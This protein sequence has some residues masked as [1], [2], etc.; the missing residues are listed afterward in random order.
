MKKTAS[1]QPPTQPSSHPPAGTKGGART[2]SH[3]RAAGRGAAHSR[4]RR[5]PLNIE[6]LKDFVSEMLAVEKAG[7]RLYDKA[8]Q[9]LTH[10]ELR[11]RLKRYYEQTQR[12]VEMCEEML[13]LA[14]AERDYLSAG[15][16]LAEQKAE[17]LLSTEADQEQR[18]RNNLEN[19]LLAE[20]KCD[21]DWELLSSIIGE[22]DD[23]QLRRGVR[24]MTGQ[25]L[26]Q[27]RD[28]VKWVSDKVASLCLELA[29][30]AGLSNNEERTE[31]N[32]GELTGRASDRS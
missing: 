30:R 11:D 12:H 19:L 5:A 23:R 15:A 17:G 29:H 2:N 21:A 18:D 26:R 13:E 4:K 27:E 31:E 22:I 8:L 25:V 28:H 1:K 24:R 9:E 20:T 3:S 16:Q 7:L 14:G 32:E 6:W 10:D